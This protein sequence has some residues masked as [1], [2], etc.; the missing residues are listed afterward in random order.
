M[1]FFSKHQHSGGSK[2]TEIRPVNAPQV[3]TIF[4]PNQ[5]TAKQ[6][7][8][9]FSPGAN[10]DKEVLVSRANLASWQANGY[11]KDQPRNLQNDEK[12]NGNGNNQEYN[13]SSVSQTT[14]VSAA[15]EN[16]RRARRER[17]MASEQGTYS[18]L[19]H[20]FIM[21]DFFKS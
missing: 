15:S 6:I 2:A 14:T 12:M 20:L 13:N 3:L 19:T 8:G 7:N 21:N 9:R 16:R 18:V 1:L 5:S 17:K 10:D 11:Q 4:D